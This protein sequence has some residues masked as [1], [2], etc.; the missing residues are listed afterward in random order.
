[1][2]GSD[3]ME[4]LRKQLREQNELLQG[5]NQL[6]QGKDQVIQA[7][8]QLLQKSTILELLDACH[9]HIDTHFTIEP[10]PK[11]T[12][13]GTITK[14]DGRHHPA[15]LK[16]WLDFPDLQSNTFQRVLDAL[17][18]P[19]SS[20][21]REFWKCNTIQD[22]AQGIQGTTIASEV[23]LRNWQ[24]KYIEPIVSQLC[25]ALGANVAY[26]PTSHALKPDP[27]DVLHHKAAIPPLD[28]RGATRVPV[29][30]DQFCVYGS[31]IGDQQLVAHVVELKAPH[32]MREQV[33][34]DSIMDEA[35]IDVVKVRDGYKIPTKEPRKT[36]HHGRRLLAIAT[37]QTYDY[38]LDCGCSYGCIVTGETLV[39]LKIDEADTTTL[40]Y[41]IAN[42]FREAGGKTGPFE[43]S[44]TSVAQALTFFLIASSSVPHGQDW[45]QEAKAAAPVWI[46]DHDKVPHE[47]TP[48]KR[49]K[50]LD[51]LDRE[52]FSY[53]KPRP[54]TSNRSPVKTR[55]RNQQSCNPAVQG[56]AKGDQDSDD[57]DDN[58][59]DDKALQSKGPT[60]TKTGYVPGGQRSQQASYGQA[61]TEKQQERSYCTQA[62]MLGLVQQGPIDEACPNAGLHPRGEGGNVHA[63]TGPKLCELLRQQLART[64]NHDIEDLGLRGARGMVFKLSLASHGYTFIGK[65]TIDFYV[66]ELIHEG[67]VYQRLRALQGDLVPVRLGSIDL[68]HPWYCP[69]TQLVH[70][71]LLSYGGEPVWDIPAG[72]GPRVRQFV[73]ALRARGVRHEDTRPENMLWNPEFEGLMFID[74]ERSI[75]TSEDALDGSLPTRGTKKRKAVE[76]LKP[77]YDEPDRTKRLRRE[78]GEI[79]APVSPQV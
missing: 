79:I 77:S 42:P 51:N 44:K 78:A 12:T 59:P 57:G 69:G 70:M 27:S 75:M 49:R 64:M 22:L 31:S 41:H 50:M 66:P 58:Q 37:T 3:S 20:P 6:L 71:L 36:I 7:Q 39:F 10:N 54:S 17:H 21:K 32:K 43:A 30:A 11:K 53:S 1:M 25:T 40:H 16:P 2:A 19:D 34:R 46:V 67:R 76:E 9:K 62:C 38:M 26:Y 24:Y 8:T 33:L 56:A 65:A 29:Y 61:S 60:T 5:Q 55:S 35:I 13:A 18:P 4:E 28:L 14:P 73:M 52:D 74:F 72:A 45:I 23:D 15:L 47:E 68:V 48:E 63:L